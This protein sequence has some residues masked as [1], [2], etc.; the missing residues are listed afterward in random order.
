MR[1]PVIAGNWKTNKTI[2]EAR[3]LCQA[4]LAALG[5]VTATGGPEVVV[6]PPYTALFAARETLEGS[7][8]GLGAQ[9]VFWK[10]AGAYTGQVSVLM[11]KDAGCT[12][13]IIGHSE[14][15][16]RFGVPEAGFTDEVLAHFGD[17]DRTVNLKV[18]AAVAGGLTPIVC[19]GELL[20]E[21]QDGRA[22]GVIRGQIEAGLD[23]LSPEQVGALI[24]A[25]EPVWAIGTGEVCPAGEANRVC[26]VVRAAV[27][28]RFG[29]AV[30]ETVRILYGGSANPQTAPEILGQEQIDGAL[31]GGASLKA[32]DF[33]AIIRMVSG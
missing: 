2:S 22:D 3:E 10:P 25:Y 21:R 29:A 11:L 20:S 33:S 16:G 14:K 19:C 15:R 28:E 13:A 24:I 23:G 30:A 1:R 26:G 32:G 4:L 31:V 6:C 8:V 7:G 27:G 18:H 17:S 5:H 9:D 12:H